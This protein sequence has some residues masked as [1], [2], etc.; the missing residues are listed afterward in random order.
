MIQGR[1]K[2]NQLFIRLRNHNL[3]KQAQVTN[4]I[5]I[6]AEMEQVNLLQRI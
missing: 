6:L 2:K 3:I 4:R 5:N 1:F